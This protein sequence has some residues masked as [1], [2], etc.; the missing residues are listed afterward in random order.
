[1][2]NQTNRRAFTLVELLVVV[3]VI[4]LLIGLLLPALGKARQ[5]AWTIV[6]GNMQRQ[7]AIGVLSYTSS[8][9][10]WIPGANSSGKFYDN[11]N[12]GSGSPIF[13]RANSDGGQPLQRWDWMS[14]S[15][16]DSDLPVGIGQRYRALFERF[17]DPAV[18]L[19]TTVYSAGN[20]GAEWKDLVR[21]EISKNGS[22]RAPSFLMPAT[23]QWFARNPTGA[24]NPP[25]SDGGLVTSDEGVT[26]GY[27]QPAFAGPVVSQ[28]KADLPSYDPKIDRLQNPSSKICIATAFRY[29]PG[30]SGNFIPDIDVRPGSGIYGS[31]TCSTATYKDATEFGDPTTSTNENKGEALLLSYRH[32]NK[33]SAA[34]WDGS[35]KIITQSESRNPTLWY[36]KGSKY[37]GVTAHPDAAQ[38]Y[39][40]GDRIN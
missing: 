2:S 24:A 27:V 36:P 40:P 22:L 35:V 34:M 5:S 10:G 17:S 9:D 20:G 6:A 28:I 32:A 25:S 21:Q 13:K 14:P 15:L 26:L 37:N 19:N 11:E 18:K 33:M 29:L 39:K 31:F 8:S 16:A 3:A 7:L 4:A 38:F 12:I 1:M 30:Q 23:F